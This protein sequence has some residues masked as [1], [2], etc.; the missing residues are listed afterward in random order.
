MSECK[1][2]GASGL[3]WRKRPG[4]GPKQQGAWLLLQGAPEPAGD[5]VVINDR[6]VQ[7]ERDEHGADAPRYAPH[8][9]YCTSRERARGPNP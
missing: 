4:Y 9:A 2:C 1:R 8:A 7:Y 5:Y 6:V 3:T